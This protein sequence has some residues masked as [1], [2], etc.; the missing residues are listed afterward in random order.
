MKYSVVL[1]DLDG[2]LLDTLGD[3]TAAVNYAMASKG[4]PAR[5]IDEVRAFVGNGIANLIA[6]SVPTGTDEQT[7]AACLANFRAY[8]AEHMAVHTAPYDGILPLLDRLKAAG[9]R[10][11]VVSNKVDFAVRQLCEQYFGDRVDVAVGECEGLRCKPAPDT[12]Q[13]ALAALGVAADKAVYIGDSDVDIRTA[14][15][16]GMP[17]ISVDWGFRSR[18][19]LQE[20]GAR[21]IVSTTAE[22]EQELA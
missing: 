19:F 13:K 20:N 8:Y 10:V 9:C 5:T 3:L 15:N 18:A 16:A 2:T 1:F 22:L 21:V 4:F 11:G 6:R 14:E 7:V 12:V 17:C